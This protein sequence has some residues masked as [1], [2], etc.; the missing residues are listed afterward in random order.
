M[1]K[2]RL[3]VSV[4]ALLA[5]GSC[6]PAAPTGEA[7][8][9]EAEA[10]HDEAQASHDGAQGAAGEHAALTLKEI[11][12]GL[13]RDMATAAHGL[14]IEDRASVGA[15]AR[16]VAEHPHVTSEQ[17]AVIQAA[18][19]DDFTAFVRH[20]QE[21]H[22]AAVALTEAAATADAGL[23]AGYVRVQEG[24]VACHTAFRTRLAAV[25]NPGG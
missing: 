9:T 10:S 4:L 15:G 2:N 25:L 20:D 17:M 8:H 11:M 5:V 6:G 7:L 3:S 12:Q 18:L 13:E 23:L 16:G 14:W 22:G 24:C 1:T 21:V 19:G